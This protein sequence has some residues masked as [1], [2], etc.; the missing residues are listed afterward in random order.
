M[1][2]V[3]A[4]AI[5]LVL[6]Y[7]AIR[8]YYRQRT[9]RALSLFR[10]AKQAIMARGEL[11]DDYPNLKEY[12]L[13]KGSQKCLYTELQLYPDDWLRIVSIT[14][15]GQ[16]VLTL[17]DSEKGGLGIWELRSWKQAES[18]VSSLQEAMK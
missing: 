3:I 18:I 8:F 17:V 13:R 12:C 1:I 9:R 16:T 4:A 15:D 14:V 5:T 6:G 2:N 7:A 10:N 11:I